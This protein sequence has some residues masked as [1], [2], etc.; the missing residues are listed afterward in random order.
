[1]PDDAGTD[2][3]QDPYFEN[4][5][6]VG[7]RICSPDIFAPS[8]CDFEDAVQG[9]VDVYEDGAEAFC[10]DNGFTEPCPAGLFVEPGVACPAPPE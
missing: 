9:D 1:M 7:V 2:G 8:A 3:V 4:P 6:A 5:E 10:A